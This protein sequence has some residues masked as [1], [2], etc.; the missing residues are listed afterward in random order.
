MERSKKVIFVSHY[1]LNQNSMARGRERAPGVVKELIELIAEAGIG[2]VQ[3]PDPE[4]E[5]FGLDRSH[6]DK[7]SIDTKAYRALCRKHACQILK[8]IEMYLKKNYSVVGIL[9][10]EF[11]PTWAVHQIQNG[12]RSVPGKG[13][14][15]E[16]LENEMRKKRFQVPIIGINLNNIF[17]SS[18]KLQ[19]LISCA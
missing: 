15:I 10:V 9:G 14:L 18:E 3:L 1:L 8:Q 19:A 17:S 2:I 12:S 11:S 4:L 13:I 6:K 5:Y 16:E 7:T